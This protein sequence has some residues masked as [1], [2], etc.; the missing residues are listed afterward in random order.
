MDEGI[1]KKLALALDQQGVVVTSVEPRRPS[2]RS[3]SAT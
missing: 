2:A 3:S 1:R